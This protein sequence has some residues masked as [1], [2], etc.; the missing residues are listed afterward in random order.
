MTK[1][2]A[3]S[4]KKLTFRFNKMLKTPCRIEN[5]EKFLVCEGGIKD[6]NDLLCKS[7]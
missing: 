4:R 1:F 7:L 2:N 5:I 3:S 6:L